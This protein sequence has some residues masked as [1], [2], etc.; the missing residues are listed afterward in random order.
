[1]EP[2][3]ASDENRPAS[4]QSV[5]P[6]WKCAANPEAEKR[7]QIQLM[8]AEVLFKKQDYA[9]AAP[10]YSTLELSRQLTGNMKAEALFKLGWCQMELKALDQ[11]SM[12]TARGKCV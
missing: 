7:D 10:L 1:M 2:A 4:F 11:L 8:K 5:G 9:N 6:S 12:D 3:T